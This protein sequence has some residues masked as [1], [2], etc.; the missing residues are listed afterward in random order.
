MPAPS[1]F[2]GSFSAA[3]PLPRAPADR[4]TGPALRPHRG[5]PEERRPPRRL[6]G[7]QRGGFFR[8]DRGWAAKGPR[9][10]PGSAARGRGAPDPAARQADGP[11]TRIRAIRR[12]P[13]TA[14]RAAGFRGVAS[15]PGEAVQ[16]GHDPCRGRES[17]AVFRRAVGMPAGAGFSQSAAMRKGCGSAG[18]SVRGGKKNFES[19]CCRK[20]EYAN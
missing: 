3:R 5:S 14:A 16:C 17:R 20:R 2:H 13:A 15:P 9:R 12:T 10:R 19:G 18:S 11:G 4:P 6:P 7:R 8:N 1:S